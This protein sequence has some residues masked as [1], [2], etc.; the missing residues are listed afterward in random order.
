MHSETFISNI[1]FSTT[2]N[3][4]KRSC[5]NAIEFEFYPPFFRSDLRG[6]LHLILFSF[7]PISLLYETPVSTLHIWQGSEYGCTT[8]TKVKRWGRLGS[9]E[10]NLSSNCNPQDE[11]I[12][13]FFSTTISVLFLCLWRD[14]EYWC[15]H[16]HSVLPIKASS[17][18]S[19]PV[20]S[21][22]MRGKANIKKEEGSGGK[23]VYVAC[24]LAQQQPQP[25]SA[26]WMVGVYI[27]FACL[28]LSFFSPFKTILA[29]SMN[30]LQPGRLALIASRYI[31]A[32][33]LWNVRI[34]EESLTTTIC[35]DILNIGMVGD[36]IFRP[37][38]P[39][40]YQNSNSE[41]ITTG[42]T[43]RSKRKQGPKTNL[44]LANRKEW[45][46]LFPSAK[47]EPSSKREKTEEGKP[48][49]CFIHTYKVF[50]PFLW[51]SHF[52]LK[53][54]LCFAIYEQSNTRKCSIKTHFPRVS[55]PQTGRSHRSGTS[56]HFRR[57]V[58]DFSIYPLFHVNVVNEWM[59][60]S[61]HLQRS[62]VCVQ[63]HR[64]FSSG[65]PTCYSTS[66]MD[67]LECFDTC[68]SSLKSWP[69][70]SVKSTCH[71]D[72]SFRALRY[73]KHRDRPSNHYAF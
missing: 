66:E 67:Q 38:V 31:R 22:F 33:V 9:K 34:D 36:L 68:H 44:Q 32:H 37:C 39:T 53:C 2:Y 63:L 42:Q 28:L 41:K 45:K 49:W 27:F 55:L 61:T 23:Y 3:E 25:V 71:N 4:R 26:S 7:P 15:S 56:P 50:V 35:I 70:I 40:H 64:K 72:F 57:T 8:C 48:C 60:Q 14:I 5:L 6:L 43:L 54:C 24:Q 46:F 62:D 20:W 58:R 73:L 30:K 11:G 18:W 69:R 65:C 12:S 29:V 52:P 13:L 1:I 10:Q 16:S 21:T 59:N 17:S 19:H 47:M 51:Q